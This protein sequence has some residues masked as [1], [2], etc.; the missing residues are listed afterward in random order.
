MT[1]FYCIL[2]KHTLFNLT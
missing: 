1:T 2:A